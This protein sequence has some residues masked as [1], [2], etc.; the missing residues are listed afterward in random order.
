VGALLGLKAIDRESRYGDPERKVATY[1]E[2]MRASIES[3]R[4]LGYKAFQ[5]TITA[6]P[7]PRFDADPRVGYLDHHHDTRPHRPG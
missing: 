7:V 4:R 5:N 6:A 2:F 1:L 3:R